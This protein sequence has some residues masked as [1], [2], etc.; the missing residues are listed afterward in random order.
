MDTLRKQFFVQ[1]VRD[2]ATLVPGTAS[3]QRGGALRF[4]GGLASS[5]DRGRGPLDALHV[6]LEAIDGLH[7][8]LVGAVQTLI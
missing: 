8:C 1:V 2:M 4:G 7:E 6:G 5:L 3:N